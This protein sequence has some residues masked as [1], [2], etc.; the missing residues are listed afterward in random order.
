MLLLCLLRNSCAFLSQENT[1]GKLAKRVNPAAAQMGA[2]AGEKAVEMG[3]KV[4]EKQLEMNEKQRGKVDQFLGEEVRQNGNSKIWCTQT[5][6]G[7]EGH[8]GN[9]DVILASWLCIVTKKGGQN[10][11]SCDS[12][13]ILPT[14]FPFCSVVAA[15]S[16][17]LL[18]WLLH[19]FSF[20]MFSL[21]YSQLCFSLLSYP[22]F[23]LYRNWISVNKMNLNL[24][25]NFEKCLR[26]KESYFEDHL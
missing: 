11:P 17:A 16:K 24:N 15:N 2:K 21:M 7:A 19:S 3:A 9:C 20:V 22:S 8:E 25:L 4:A 5:W 23:L 26:K 13:K 12:W 6:T 10:I 18:L 1:A 14:P